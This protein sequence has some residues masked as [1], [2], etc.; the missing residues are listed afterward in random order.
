M[1]RMIDGWTA[2]RVFNQ[3]SFA[4]INNELQQVQNTAPIPLGPLAIYVR[5]IEPRQE[6]MN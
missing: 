6:N 5:P 1:D 3:P 4:D 2:Q